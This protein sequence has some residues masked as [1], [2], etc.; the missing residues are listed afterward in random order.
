ME[1]EKKVSTNK[2]KN[3]LK[4]FWVFFFPLMKILEWSLKLVCR[5]L[6][7]EVWKFLMSSKKNLIAELK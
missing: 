6:R 3:L 5:G 1:G 2:N 7:K 4:Y